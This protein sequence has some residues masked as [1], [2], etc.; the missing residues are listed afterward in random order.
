MLV[1]ADNQNDELAAIP[2][3]DVPAVPMDE[4]FCIMCGQA[5][6]PTDQRCKN[7]GTVR[8]SDAELEDAGSSP[9]DTAY[10]MTAVEKI[11]NSTSFMLPKEADGFVS[12]GVRNHQF[13]QWLEEDRLHTINCKTLPLTIMTWLT[14]ILVAWNHGNIDDTFRMQRCLTGA[15]D[16]IKAHHVVAGLGQDI[17][18]VLN[19]ATVTSVDEMWSWIEG[20]LVPAMAGTPMKP[21][22]IRTFNQVIGQ[23]QLRETRFQPG[24]CQVGKELEA[25]YRQGCHTADDI[26][27]APYGGDDGNMTDR[28]FL[29]GYDLGGSLS[30]FNSKRFFSWLDVRR[31]DIG[32]A[33]ANALRKSKWIDDGSKS[34]EITIVF[35]NAEIQAYGH[36]SIMLKLMRGGLIKVDMEVRSLWA[37]M[38]TEWYHYFADI[39]WAL[40]TLKFIANSVQ[41]AVDNK[42]AK[43]CLVRCCTMPPKSGGGYWLMLDWIGTLLALYLMSFILIFSSGYAALAT[44]VGNL[45]VGPQP[46]QGNATDEMMSSWDDT[47][48]K[49]CA[50]TAG[51]IEDIES[52]MFFKVL[53]RLGMFWYAMVFLLRWFKGFRG[54]ARMAQITSTLS[55]ALSDLLHFAVIFAVLFVNFALA[56]HVLFGSEVSEWSTVTKSLQSAMGMVYGRVDF[57]PMYEI[58]PLSGLIWLLGFVVT[59]TMISMN[60]LL[61][62]IAD[63]YGGVFHANNAGDKGYDLFGQ[64]HAMLYEIWW[65]TTYVG[66]WLYRFAYSFFPWKLQDFKYTPRLEDEE[67]RLEIPYEEI[68]WTCEM[69]PLGYT[70][71][72]TLRHAGCDKVTARHI[73][74]RCEDEVL[75]HLD[76][77]YPLELLFDEFD[78]SMQQYYFAMDTFSNELRSW[79]SDKSIGAARMITAKKQRT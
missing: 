39:F 38:Y 15:I 22:F 43:R 6:A 46:L 24:E 52:L 35:F 50:D 71:V 1:P 59:M 33:R 64:M 8:Q 4:A 61:A 16:E 68:Y 19:L 42:K 30:E 69:D 7:C 70:S 11:K 40:C 28:A 18:S 62:I 75:R 65:N 27:S 36:V 47:Y 45:G 78:E 5:L 32:R 2:P 13:C 67:T 31:P 72:N 54:Q 57:N 3:A 12:D 73:L 66:R 37:T 74:K 14:F 10:E 53:H 77:F 29:P 76:E 34:M 9:S 21:A 49:F 25:Y 26:S 41:Q 44:K 55:S 60:M 48:G 20:G 79:F 63:H 51:I 23:I 58:A 56:G 17:H